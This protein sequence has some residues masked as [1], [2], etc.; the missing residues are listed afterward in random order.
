MGVAYLFLLLLGS[1][2]VIPCE[3]KAHRGRAKDWVTYQYNT[4]TKT[5][6]MSGKRIRG[7]WRENMK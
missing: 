5:L 3:A 1:M 2:I 7:C 4:K 6:T